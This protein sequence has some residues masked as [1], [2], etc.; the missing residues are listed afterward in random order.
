M[1]RILTSAV[2]ACILWCA[3][4]APVLAQTSGS[5]SDWLLTAAGA[6]S[7]AKV[8]LN[9]D[10]TVE[11]ITRGPCG[12]TNCGFTIQGGRPL[13]QLAEIEGSILVIR[14]ARLNSWPIL[15][16]YAHLSANEGIL[17]VWVHD[18]RRFVS[19]ASIRLQGADVERVLAPLQGLPV[20]PPSP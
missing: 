15:H 3:W 2:G 20:G 16:S 6:V 13:Q 11:E 9:G 8:D 19:V 4:P 7:G 10:G 18:G 17:D 1:A 14:A 12:V 5:N